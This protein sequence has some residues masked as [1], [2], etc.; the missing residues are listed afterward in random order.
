MIWHP[1]SYWTSQLSPQLKTWLFDPTSLTQRLQAQCQSQFSVTVLN[2]MW[3]TPWE[4][5]Q[6]A[7]NP[8]P[9]IAWLRHVYLCCHERPWVFARTVIPEPTLQNEYR[10]LMNLGTQPLGEVLF[11]FH[12]LQRTEI[13]AICLSESHPLYQL[14]SAQL[15]PKPE[16]LWARRSMFYLPEDQPLLVQEVFLPQMLSELGCVI[17]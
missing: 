6:Y 1:A 11:S 3:A 2:E 7:F 14:A 13:E 16:R 9:S 10:S 5:E 12:A 4:D 8:A 15:H 17:K